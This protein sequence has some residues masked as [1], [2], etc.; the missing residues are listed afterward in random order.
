MNVWVREKS[1]RVR[2]LSKESLVAGTRDGHAGEV[3]RGLMS[4][5]CVFIDELIFVC[6]WL[7]GERKRESPQG[8][9]QEEI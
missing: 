9:R 7:E 1:L 6:V 5:V 3:L 4:L 8:T 2:D